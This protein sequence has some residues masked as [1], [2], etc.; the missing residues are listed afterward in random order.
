MPASL[1]I[2]LLNL[3][4]SLFNEALTIKGT[5][6]AKT[7]ADVDAALAAARTAAMADISKALADLAPKS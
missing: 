5:L 2:A 7:Q 4:P 1:I 3:V 6:D